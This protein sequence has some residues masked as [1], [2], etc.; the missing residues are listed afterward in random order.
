MWPTFSAKVWYDYSLLRYNISRH[1]AK[2][3]LTPFKASHI[4]IW[5]PQA[6]STTAV[7]P[8]PLLGI[9]CWQVE[10]SSMGM[11]DML[12]GEEMKGWS[13]ILLYWN[14]SGNTI[15]QVRI[16]LPYVKWWKTIKIESDLMKIMANKNQWVFFIQSQACFSRNILFSSNFCSLSSIRSQKAK[17]IY[18]FWVL[19]KFNQQIVIKNFKLA[20]SEIPLG[21]FWIAIWNKKNKI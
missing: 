18:Y 13:K 14:G 6:A 7:Q 20:T 1:R 15:S 2:I 12:M 10:T 21:D 5:H 9:W 8:L 3:C 11:C 4:S 19:T 17:L 16:R